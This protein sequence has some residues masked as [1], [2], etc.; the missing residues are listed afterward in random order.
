MKRFLSKR[1]SARAQ[2]GI[3]LLVVT[4]MILAIIL[5]TLTAFHV[6]KTQYKLVGNIQASELAFARAESTSAAA[7]GWLS[8][9]ANARSIAFDVYDP[10]SA[11][12]YPKGEL[13]TLD[14][15]PATMTWSNSNSL[16]S[17]GGRYLIELLGRGIRGPG[18]SLA[19]GQNAAS[20]KLVDL[21]RVVAKADAG[22][23][24]SRIIETVEATD[25]C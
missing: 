7:R 14:F 1:S 20:C 9:Q 13:A 5:I 12:L 2:R 3:S 10:T 6:S 15:A 16:D 24:A 25:G 21:F 4:V 8:I 22:Q 17:A 19:L 11:H 18:D 23:D